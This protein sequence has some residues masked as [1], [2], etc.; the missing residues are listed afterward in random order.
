MPITLP[1]P[2]PQAFSDRL[3][4]T[5]EA[6]GIEARGRGVKLAA[7]FDVKQP[8][9]HAWLK[10]KHLPEADKVL[11]MSEHWKVGFEWLYFGRGELP[12]AIRRLRGETDPDAP[13]TPEQAIDRLRGDIQAVRAAL[14]AFAAA[15]NSRLPGVAAGFLENFRHTARDHYYAER[16][17]H[18]LLEG[19]LERIAESEAA[20]QPTAPVDQALAASQK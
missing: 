6:R 10:G 20:A 7:L 11:A 3:N 9:A 14:I 1:K 19:A 15:A 2:D 13:A 17:F 16:G 18:A 8:T 4:E 5:M 12:S